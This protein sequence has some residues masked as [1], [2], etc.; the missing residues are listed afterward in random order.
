MKDE[1]R[2]RLAHRRAED[3]PPAPD[4]QVRPADSRCPRPSSEKRSLPPQCCGGGTAD[5]DQ[6]FSPEVVEAAIRDGRW[7]AL[8]LEVGTAEQAP[9]A[10]GPEPSGKNSPSSGLDLEELKKVIDQSLA[11]GVQRIQVKDRGR[12]QSDSRVMPLVRSLRERDLDVELFTDDLAISREA[13][14]ELFS[15]GVAVVLRGQDHGFDSWDYSAGRQSA[16]GTVPPGTANLLAAGYPGAGRR[17][18]VET[19]ALRSNVGRIPEMWRW[20]RR[21]GIIPMV[22]RFPGNEGRDGDRDAAL[23]IR[24]LKD[25]FS[26]LSAIDAEEFDI[27]WKPQPPQAG[28]GCRRLL[29][30]LAVAADGD[31]RPCLGLEWPL[32][33]VRRESLQA[34]VINAPLLRDLRAIRSRIQG[35]CRICRLSGGC[36]GCR[37][38]AFFVAGDPLASDPF[39]WQKRVPEDDAERIPSNENLP[40]KEA[41]SL[42]RGPADLDDNKI[43]L[44]LSVPPDGIF[45]N[46]DEALAPLALVEMLAQ[47]C[48]AQQA[49]ERGPAF[50]GRVLGYLIGMDNV[51][52]Y[53]PVL[54]GDR[55]D[56]VVWNTVELNEIHRV[57]GEVFRGK[58][59]VAQA[60]LT[61]FKANEWLNPHPPAGAPPERGTLTDADVARW[62]KGRDGVGRGLIRNFARLTIDPGQSVK[63]AICLPPDFVGFSGHFPGYPVLPGVAIVY[64]GLLLA[65]MCDEHRLDL[66]AVKR[67]R[68]IKPIHP[69]SPVEVVL[70]RNENE[71][72]GLIWYS[73]KV[74]C[75]GEPAAKYEI[76]TKRI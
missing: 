67:A 25:L 1:A 53:R 66:A 40:H 29:Y 68:F 47:L 33:N 51:K 23:S 74:L 41:M 18:G 56:L 75:H 50:D 63:A 65:E 7:L 62:S 16:P 31:V 55:L 8:E 20:A 76:G 28:Q 3:P 52:F 43:L 12:V 61:L 72:E 45:M 35:Y 30:S 49:H 42:I 36:Y 4:P 69:G 11:L 32:G 13:A 10:R 24:E 34:I 73:V 58:A 57:Q 5:P 70:K 44:S 14:Q 2:A 48:A 54:S 39:C 15:L 22:D 27:R 17:L 64:A 21:R 6:D 38:T 37:A 46:P 71:N 60:E 19:V 9:D 59:L 26:E